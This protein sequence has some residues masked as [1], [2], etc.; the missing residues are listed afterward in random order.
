MGCYLYNCGMD[1]CLEFMA[2]IGINLDCNADLNEVFKRRRDINNNKIRHFTPQRDAFVNEAARSNKEYLKRMLK[3]LGANEIEKIIGYEFKE[4]SF[5]LEA[6]THP[7]YEDNRLTHSYEKLEFLGDAVLDYLVTCYIFTHTNADPGKLTDIRSALVCNNMFA[8]I[9]TDSNLDKFILHCTPGIMSKINSF[10]DS[11]YFSKHAD[12]KQRINETVK[13]FNEDEV[14]EMEE[15][16]VPKVLGDVFEAIIGAIFIDSGHDLVT[17][18]K[19]YRRLCPNFEEIVKNPPQ[20]MKKELLEKFPG[21]GQVK[22]SKARVD[23]ETVQVEVEVIV[24][25]QKR[26]FRGRGKN[27]NLAS[28]GACKCALRAIREASF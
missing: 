3:K 10:L 4:K 25:G 12:F 28:L 1:H 17:V 21:Q 26:R 8:S 22:F 27:K 19:I 14:L 13:Q 2:R 20:N 7:S 9:L 16:E 15:I 23:G 5:L 11:R 6:F 24:E 18:W